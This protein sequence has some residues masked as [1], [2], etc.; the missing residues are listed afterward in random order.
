MAKNTKE[1]GVSGQKGAMG[2]VVRHYLMVF[3]TY[4]SNG[5]GWKT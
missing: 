4:G 5:D 3:V 2:R 1:W